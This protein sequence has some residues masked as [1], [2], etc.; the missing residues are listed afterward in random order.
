[1]TIQ[2]ILAPAIIPNPF[3][4]IGQFRDHGTRLTQRV[5]GRRGGDALRLRGITRVRAFAGTRRCGTPQLAASYS[6]GPC[7]LSCPLEE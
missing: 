7:L 4:F 2:L 3:R 6:T 5:A 1:M